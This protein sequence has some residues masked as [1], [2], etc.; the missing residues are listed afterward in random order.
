MPRIS[1]A[2]KSAVPE[3]I[4][5]VYEEQERSRGMPSPGTPIYGLRPS[6]FRG[7]RALAAGIDESGLLEPDIRRLATLRAASP[8]FQEFSI[9]LPAKLIRIRR[10]FN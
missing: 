1:G 3:D 4:R 7:H 6:I 10:A 8:H 9:I 2:M 5:V